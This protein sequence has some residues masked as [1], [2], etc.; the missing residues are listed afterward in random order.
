[1]AYTRPYLNTPALEAATE[2]SAPTPGGAAGVYTFNNGVEWAMVSNLSTN[3]Y[4]LYVRWNQTT[5]SATSWD[6]VIEPGGQ[7]QF[8]L[9]L[10]DGRFVRTVAVY[11]PTGASYTYNT[12]FNVRGAN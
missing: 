5:A 2:T 1:M 9:A 12:H 11:V 7:A 8:P 3:A 10:D 4:P 6:D